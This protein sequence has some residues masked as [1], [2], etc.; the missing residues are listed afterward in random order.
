MSPSEQALGHDTGAVVIR[1]AVVSKVDHQVWERVWVEALRRPWSSLALV[2][3]G[4]SVYAGFAA[5]PLAELG[6]QYF[7]GGVQAV[8][9][10]GMSMGECRS[11]LES[12]EDKCRGGKRVIVSV[13][14]P[15]KTQVAVVIARAVDIALLVV[16]EEVSPFAAARETIQQIGA[17]RFVGSVI[18]RTGAGRR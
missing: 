2:P 18:V 11:F 13:D 3:A 12:L 8:R 4:R 7:G 6:R 9:G 14:S 17:E 15:Q 10:E 1:P 5:E 16:A